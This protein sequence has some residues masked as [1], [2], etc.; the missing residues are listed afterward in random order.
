MAC[1]TPSIGAVGSGYLLR[2]GDHE[3]MREIFLSTGCIRRVCNGLA[4]AV[5]FISPIASK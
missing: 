1:A 2:L 3:G 4:R 5:D